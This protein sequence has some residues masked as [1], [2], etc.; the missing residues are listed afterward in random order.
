MI[1][2]QRA[3]QS[4][5]VILFRLHA[6]SL[7][8]RS[9]PAT[10]T[11]EG[12]AAVW[13]GQSPVSWEGGLAACWTL[14]SR[15]YTRGTGA[16]NK[17]FTIKEEK[18]LTRGDFKTSI[19]ARV[20]FHLYWQHSA[21]SRSH[22]VMMLQRAAQAGYLRHNSIL[23]FPAAGASAGASASAASLPR[24][25]RFYQ[26]GPSSPA[27]AQA[28]TTMGHRSHPAHRQYAHITGHATFFILYDK[29][30]M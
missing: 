23:V 5:S 16:G 29:D 9:R 4:N 1:H 11:A 13:A 10:H 7:L 22:G 6:C 3:E 26:A 27:Q 18:A 25:G 19:F 2:E 8:L 30:I 28:G 15:D 17:P 14:D 21:G 24:P 20:R 12:G